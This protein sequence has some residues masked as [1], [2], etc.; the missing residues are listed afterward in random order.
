M[1]NSLHVLIIIESGAVGW[2]VTLPAIVFVDLL[3]VFS[4]IGVTFCG[5]MAGLTMDIFDSRFSVLE[6]ALIGGVAGQT[7]WVGGLIFFDQGVEGAGVRGGCPVG[8]L[9]GMTGL[10]PLF[11]GE[12]KRGGNNHF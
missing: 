4:G 12:R 8:V 7:G 5:A 2:I 9:A 1:K 3:K 11:W 10:A 6:N